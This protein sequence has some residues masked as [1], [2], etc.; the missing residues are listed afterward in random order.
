MLYVYFYAN[1]CYV[2]YARNNCASNRTFRSI[3][4]DCRDSWK[5]A[6]YVT[7]RNVIRPTVR[8]A[9]VHYDSRSLIFYGDSNSLRS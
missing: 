9:L 2:Q 1:V 8:S 4:L 7:E 5:T 3:G 6:D